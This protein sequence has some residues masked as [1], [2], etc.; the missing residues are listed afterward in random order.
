MNLINQILNSS[1]SKSIIRNKHKKQYFIQKTCVFQKKVVTLQCQ[2][3][4]F[5]GKDSYVRR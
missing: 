3:I 1:N 4:M 2:T 5:D